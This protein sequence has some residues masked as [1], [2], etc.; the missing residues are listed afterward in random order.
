MAAKWSDK[1]FNKSVE[2]ARDTYPNNGNWWTA[3]STHDFLINNDIPCIRFQDKISEAAIKK[4]LNNGN[5]IIV[6]IDTKDI[7]YNNNAEQRTDRYYNI[8]ERHFIIIKGYRAEENKTY[9]E[10]YDPNT[11][12]MYYSDGTQKGKNRYYWSNEVIYS[13]LNLESHYIVISPK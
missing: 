6:L 1:S 8:N 5:I 4:H 9:F 2:N 10:V 11:W 7:T 3:S 12:D 13:I